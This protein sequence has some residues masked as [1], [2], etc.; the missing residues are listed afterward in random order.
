MFERLVTVVR[1]FVPAFLCLPTLCL[2]EWES[3]HVCCVNTS[4]S[5]GDEALS[6]SCPGA[7]GSA[8]SLGGWGWWA[9]GQLP[10]YDPPIHPRDCW[11]S[12]GQV[13]GTSKGSPAQGAGLRGTSAV[14]PGLNSGNSWQIPGKFGAFPPSMQNSSP[15]PAPPL[16][17]PF[18]FLVIGSSSSQ[19]NGQMDRQARRQGQGR[20]SRRVHLA[21]LP[22][23]LSE[24]RLGQ[25][26]DMCVLCGYHRYKSGTWATGKSPDT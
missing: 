6:T 3:K 13:W 19:A 8:P 21:G 23:V 16:S 1:P 24:L 5:R 25:L 18:V 17:S 14:C 4:W 10:T 7:L 22:S 26:L 12:A 9:S 11:A 2:G 15:G 20:G